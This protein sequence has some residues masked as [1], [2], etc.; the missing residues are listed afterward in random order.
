MHHALSLFVYGPPNA[1]GGE[2]QEPMGEEEK[3]K[4]NDELN[5]KLFDEQEIEDLLDQ[6]EDADLENLDNEALKEALKISGL[7]LSQ[8][9]IA[10]LTAAYTALMKEFGN[11]TLALGIMA[12]IVHE[13]VIGQAQKGSQNGVFS[14][15]I[16]NNLTALQQYKELYGGKS[17]APGGELTPAQMAAI[18]TK[19]MINELKGSEK[20]AYNE[21]IK[22]QNP[23]EAAVII[24]QKYERCSECNTQKKI[25]Q[26]GD[27]APSIE[28]VLRDIIK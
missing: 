21:A 11:P 20:R 9:K 25:K 14:G 13:G 3:K 15:K 2:E 8:D 10:S 5:G 6:L 22:A 26:R 7:G 23:R 18:E 27:T 4:K 16:L 1:V 12:N 17:K 28:K 24:M 19:F